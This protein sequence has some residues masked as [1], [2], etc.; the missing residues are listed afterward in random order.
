MVLKVKLFHLV[1]LFSLV[2][3]SQDLKVVYEAKYLGPTVAEYTEA[4]KEKN[5]SERR[6]RSYPESYNVMILN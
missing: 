1:V 3:F 5:Y 2:S 6:I 4:A